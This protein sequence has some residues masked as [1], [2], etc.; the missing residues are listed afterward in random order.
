MFLRRLRFSF[1]QRSFSSTHRKLTQ[2]HKPY[3]ITTPIFYPNAEPHIGHLYTLVIGD[4]FARYHRLQGRDVGFLAGTDE[5]GLKIQKAAC[6]WSGREGN[7]M[8]FCDSLSER[9]R[10]SE[11]DCKALAFILIEILQDLAKKADI[12]NTCFMRTSDPIHHR[13]V[14][15]IWVSLIYFTS[16]VLVLTNRV[17]FSGNSRKEASYTKEITLA[18]I[19]LPMNASTRNLRSSNFR[20]T[21][22][23][24]KRAP[25]SN[26]PQR[27]TTCS[28]S[29]PSETLLSH[30]TL[31]TQKLYTHRSTTKKF[32][33]YSKELQL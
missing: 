8:D 30:T 3:Y 4:V 20:L 15:D 17:S 13:A 9:F 7:E 27:K 16:S 32:F 24:S 19:L 11:R 1:S 2:T 6:T 31:P 25:W 10:V 14:Q 33:N 22:L 18:G 12:S 21:P 26:G 28:V 23:P 29:P 5:H